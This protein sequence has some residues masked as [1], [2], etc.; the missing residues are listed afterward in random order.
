[1]VDNRA[2]VTSHCTAAVYGGERVLCVVQISLT[3]AI[4]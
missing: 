4:H 1:M 2:D 3:E